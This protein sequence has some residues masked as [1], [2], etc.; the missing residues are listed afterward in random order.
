MSNGKFL[1]TPIQIISVSHPHKK[2]SGQFNIPCTYGRSCKTLTN[3][4]LFLFSLEA[5]G[6]EKETWHKCNYT[7]TR[8]SYKGTTTK[9]PYTFH[10]LPDLTNQNVQ[11]NIHH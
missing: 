2:I 4:S 5:L 1:F 9:S 11:K 6:L 10:P 8:S 7:S 3:I